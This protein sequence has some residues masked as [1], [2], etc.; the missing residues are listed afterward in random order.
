[1]KVHTLGTKFWKNIGDFPKATDHEQKS[2]KY[3]S[4]TINWL[5]QRW[6]R[7]SP[8]FIVSF[9]LGNESYQEFCCPIIKRSMTTSSP[10]TC[11]RIACA[12]FV[13]MMFGL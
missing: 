8:P 7:S 1:M 5:A 3:V 11:S 2:G 9:D 12:C 10:W 4:G 13:V 6:P